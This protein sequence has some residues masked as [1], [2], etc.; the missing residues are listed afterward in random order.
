M[1]N[2]IALNA[3]MQRALARSCRQLRTVASMTEKEKTLRR[4]IARG[5]DLSST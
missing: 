3:F 4:C 5:S 1:T 2:E